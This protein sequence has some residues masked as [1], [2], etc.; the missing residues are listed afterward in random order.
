MK[1]APHNRLTT[2]G[3]HHATPAQ[4]LAGESFPP[5]HSI[6]RAKD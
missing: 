4:K 3:T 2:P 6:Q 1:R 5:A